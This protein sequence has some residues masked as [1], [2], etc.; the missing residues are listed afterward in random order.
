MTIFLGREPEILCPSAVGT[1]FRRG[2][3][4][5]NSVGGSDGGAVLKYTS[6]LHATVAQNND[7][8]ALPLMKLL[9]DNGVDINELEY[10]GR[11]NL[12]RGA[13]LHD[14]GTAL[15]VAAEKGFVER[16]KI[17]IERGASLEAKS[18]NG[19]T[20]RDYAQ[21]YEK[22][23]MRLYLESLMRQ[24]GIEVKQLV[25]IEEDEDEILRREFDR[26][27]SITY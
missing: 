10:E 25:D 14:H 15:H 17:L 1:T 24:K 16:A 27:G 18:K 11:D 5:L 21:L 8:H 9:L 12:P 13:C 19:Y 26:E 2:I 20:P 3:A 7:A 6:A 22:E 4:R 23:E